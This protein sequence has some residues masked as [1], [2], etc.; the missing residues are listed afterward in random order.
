MIKLI[1]FDILKDG[2]KNALT[3]SYDDGRIQDHSLLEIMNRYGMKGTFHLNSG[4]LDDVNR[5]SPNEIASLYENHEIACH[6]AMHHRLS[7][8][9]QQNI[10][11]EIFDDRRELERLSGRIIRGMSYAFGDYSDEIMDVLKTCG[12]VYSRTTKSTNQFTVPQNFLKWHPTCHHKDC[13]E[14]GERFLESLDKGAYPKL[15]CVWGHSY[16][17]D[18]DDNWNLIEDFFKLIGGNEDIWYATNIEIYEYI[19]AQRQ[20]IFSTDNKLVYNPTSV[21]V[22]FSNNE[23]VYDVKPGETV[24]IE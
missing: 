12:I 14:N 8:L 6:G 15:F 11:Q 3:L 4:R 18:R 10:L 20:L 16:E 2:K 24:L 7:V 5:I 9:P 19:T 23:N 17:F 22:W 13:I 1:K 21:R